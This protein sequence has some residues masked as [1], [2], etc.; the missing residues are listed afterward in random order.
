MIFCGLPRRLYTW[1]A[2]LACECAKYLW[3]LLVGSVILYTRRLQILGVDKWCTRMC[4]VE[5]RVGYSGETDEIHHKMLRWTVFPQVGMCR[6]SC[7][8]YLWE[9]RHIRRLKLQSTRLRRGF[10]R[11]LTPSCPQICP[12]DLSKA[13]FFQFFPHSPRMEGWSCRW[14]S[15]GAYVR[16]FCSMVF[17]LFFFIEKLVLIS[18]IQILEYFLVSI[19]KSILI[20]GKLKG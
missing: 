11:V 5:M 16:I 10:I 19:E 12:L 6:R 13:V 2:S 20:T 8:S 1:G 9:N 17:S 14:I 7:V 18:R 3:I 4:C 15:I